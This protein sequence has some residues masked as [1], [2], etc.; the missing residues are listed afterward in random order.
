MSPDRTHRRSSDA[1]GRAPRGVPG[2]MKSPVRP[3]IMF[4]TVKEAAMTRQAKTPATLALAATAAL[5]ALMGSSCAQPENATAFI[6]G[7]LPISPDA[8]CLVD[9]GGGVFVSGALLDIGRG[10]N[11]ANALVLAPRVVINMPNTFQAR[12]QT[13]ARKESPNYPNYGYA[14]NNTINFQAVEVFFSSDADRPD[15][16]A[17]TGVGLPTDDATARRI[18][19]GGTVYNTQAQLNQ[20]SAIITT[21]IS[22]EDAATLQTTPYVSDA[23]ATS[24]R[25]RILVNLRLTGFTSGNSAV[26]TP[27]FVFPVDLCQGCLV[28]DEADCTNGRIDTG[29]VRGVDYPTICQ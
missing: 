15:A 1:P 2:T 24:G 21:A 4:E 8:S 23:I 29:C 7:M 11:D 10:A 6:E 25:A 26:R 22:T 9:A 14:D 13:E 12:D 5:A 16:P 28:V 20:A 27:P 18:G 19:V 3:A 17:L